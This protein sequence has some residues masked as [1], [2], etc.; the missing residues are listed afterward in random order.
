MTIWFDK[1]YLIKLDSVRCNWVKIIGSLVNGMK[2]LHQTMRRGW[3]I[4]IRSTSDGH[5]K[6]VRFSRALLLSVALLF[7]SVLSVTGWYFVEYGFSKST[8]AE[9]IKLRKE[10]DSRNAQM[11]VFAE[12]MLSVRAELSSIRRLSQTV[13]QKLGRGDVFSE[14]GL[15]GAVKK[16]IGK[17]ARRLTY[18]NYE[19]D[20]LE[21][22]WTEMEEL[23]TE[24]HLEHERSV[25]MT[26]FLDARSGLI[27]AL[28][29]IRP[30]RG[31]FISSPFGR[32]RDPFTGAVKMHTGIDLA[33]SSHVPVYATADGVVTQVKRSS[34]YGKLVGI[35]HGYG[36]YTL[37]AHLH[38]QDVKPGDRVQCGQQIGLLGS[39]GRSTHRHLH[40]EVRIEGRRVN[41]YYFLPCASVNKNKR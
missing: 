9:V 7:L 25:L 36:V 17:D 6:R 31:G 10:L 34:S 41:P 29:S 19:T 16:T 4:S 18:F 5:Y 1:L 14:G 11:S 24:A 3:E 21:D 22:M 15:G 32:R 20:F 39:T 26:G 40:Y 23:E 13:E 2:G 30:I 38:R 8:A 27:S 12:R 35:Y 37:Y 28:P 33:H